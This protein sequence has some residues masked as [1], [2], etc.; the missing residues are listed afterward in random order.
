MEFMELQNLERYRERLRTLRSR[1]RNEITGLIEA[2]PQTVAATGDLSSAPTH[3]A[4]MASEGLDAELVLVQNE[5]GILEAVERALAKIDDGTYGQCEEC[6]NNIA[7]ARLDA[8]P[9]APHCIHCAQRLEG[10][11]R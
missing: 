9:F 11:R 4:D 7:A 6:G 8:I 3:L 10:R 1:L 5:E 2:I